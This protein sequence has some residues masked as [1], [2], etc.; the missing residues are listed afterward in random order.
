MFL[1]I[2]YY[3]NQAIKYKPTEKIFRI[4]NEKN[5]DRFLV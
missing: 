4:K 5:C 3:I 1:E 2:K